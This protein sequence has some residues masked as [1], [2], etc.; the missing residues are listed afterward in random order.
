[1]LPLQRLDAACARG[2]VVETGRIIAAML[3]DLV[4][5]DAVEVYEDARSSGSDSSQTISAHDVRK[6]LELILASRHFKASRRSKQFLQYVVNEEISGHGDLLKERSLGI[7]IFG[8]KPD[9][10]AGEDPIVR[11]QAGDVRHRLERYYADPECQSSIFIEVPLGSYA[12]VFRARIDNGASEVLVPDSSAHERVDRLSASRQASEDKGAVRGYSTAESPLDDLPP[13]DKMPHAPSTSK[14][15]F[16]QP[17]TEENSPTAI[18]QAQ[19]PRNWRLLVL[20]SSAVAA[21]LVVVCWFALQYFHKRPEAF[22]KDFWLPA[23]RSSKPVLLWL[24]KP[25]V[26]RPSDK[27]FDA[28]TAAHPNALATRE[29]RQDRYLPLEGTDSINWADMV[30]VQDSG[31]GTG[32]VIAAVN[33]SKL[34]TKQ[35][36]KF[37]TR[38]GSEA[39]YAELRESPAVVVGAINTEWAPQLMSEATFAFDES[40]AAPSIYE[41]RGAKRVWKLEVIDGHKTRDYG[42]ITR[43][44]T[45]KAGQFMVQVAGVSHYGTEAASELLLDNDELSKLL[46]TNSIDLGKNNLQIVVSTDITNG[47]A[48]PAHVVAVSSW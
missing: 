30:P 32:G 18:L 12:P 9:Y 25:M 42:L 15:L 13:S 29:A 20:S 2:H 6:E 16:V 21:A 26:Y 37:E 35:G 8:R 46:Q 45:G 47:R 44:L 10:A 1:M 40:I 38:F 4:E 17:Q 34:L 33:L 22:L 39:T 7:Q 19:R 31:P 36:I 43:Q 23:A 24:P 28:Y 14:E 11:V 3:K 27:L 5:D 48:G 41:T